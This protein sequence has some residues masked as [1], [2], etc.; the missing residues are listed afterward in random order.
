MFFNTLRSE[1]TKLRTTASFWWTTALVLVVSVGV[2]AL[3]SGTSGDVGAEEAASVGMSAPLATM[4]F[5]MVGLAILLIQAIMVVTTEY[6]FGLVPQ[7]YLATPKRWPVI[8]AKFV[9][10]AVIAALIS[11]IVVVLSYGVADLLL[12]KEV[13]EMFTPFEDE[14]GR[15]L[16][17]AIPLATAVAVMFVQG[18]GLL[19]RQTA[20]AVAITIIWLLGFDQL[21]RMLPKFGADVAKAMPFQNM[22]NFINDLPY[23]GT[24]WSSWSSLGVFALW[25]VVAWAAGLLLSLRRDA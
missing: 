8:V 4:A 18:L 16:L 22:N 19:V 25:A 1:W 15:R 12:P 17:W 21:L 2:T 20:G 13:A 3:I 5:S 11:F 23:E 7:N 6:R 9:L 14:V 24:D 10:Y